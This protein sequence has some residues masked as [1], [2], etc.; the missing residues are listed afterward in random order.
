MNLLFILIIKEKFRCKAYTLLVILTITHRIHTV[1]VVKE[2]RIAANYFSFFK[3]NLPALKKN[4]IQGLSK[5][6]AKK[7][8]IF[9]G[10]GDPEGITPDQKQI[11]D[12]LRAHVCSLV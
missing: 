8:R 11:D 3:A 12:G 2:Y 6:P 5:C 1:P 4:K 7:S 9:P 10:C